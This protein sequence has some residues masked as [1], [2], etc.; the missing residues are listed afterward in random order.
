[1]DRERIEVKKEIVKELLFDRLYR[2]IELEDGVPQF[3][4][5]HLDNKDITYMLRQYDP[6]KFDTVVEILRGDTND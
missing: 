6:E 3:E 5:F 1:M 2:C 4:N